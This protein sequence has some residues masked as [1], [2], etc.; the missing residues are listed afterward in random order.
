MEKSLIRTRLLKCLVYPMSSYEAS[1][2]SRISPSTAKRH[3]R[4]L[5]NIGSLHQSENERGIIIYHLPETKHPKLCNHRSKMEDEE[6]KIEEPEIINPT[7]ITIPEGIGIILDD[8]P[9]KLDIPGDV[10]HSKRVVE[11]DKL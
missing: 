11:G 4:Y 1:I 10:E 6:P 9:I 8:T 7:N 5:Y 3:L 2:Q